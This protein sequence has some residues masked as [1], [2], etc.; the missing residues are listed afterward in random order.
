MKRTTW[1]VASAC[2][3]VTIIASAGIAPAFASD[4][5]PTENLIDYTVEDAAPTLVAGGLQFDGTT[6]GGQAVDAYRS[7]GV[8]LASVSGL[9]YTVATAPADGQADP[10]YALEVLTTGTGGYTTL[11]AEPYQN[12]LA[13]NA[14]GAFDVTDWKFWSSHLATDADGGQGQPEPLSWFEQQYP[15]AVVS[16]HGLHL[17]SA[18]AGSTSV[19]SA[20]SFDGIVT[21]FSHG[22]QATPIDVAAA[23]D[24]ATAVGDPTLTDV[25]PQTGLGTQVALYSLSSPFG[26]VY[27]D[28]QTAGVKA[29]Q[30]I[31]GLTAPTST[32]PTGAQVASGGTFVWQETAKGTITVPEVAGGTW[33][34]DGTAL[35][36]T[37]SF[38]DGTHTVTFT[39][40]SGFVVYPAD[41]PAAGTLAA[42]GSVSFTVTFVKGANGGGSAKVTDSKATTITGTAQ[43]G[44]ALTANTGTI[45]PST[46]KVAYQWLLNG[47]TLSGATGKTFTPASGG[48]VG[49]K[50]SVRVTITAAGYTSYTNTSAQTAAVKVGALTAPTPVITGAAKV[51][52]RLAIKLGTWTSGTTLH[53]QWYASGVAV[54]GQTYSS[55]TLGAAQ[56][57][58]V[59]AVKV[60]GSKSG[61]TTVVKTSAGTAKVAKGT[62]TGATPTVTVSSTVGGY[63]IVGATATAHS[64]AWTSGTAL[65]YQWYGNGIAIAG[66]TSS[67]YKIAASQLGHKLSVRVTGTK[68]GYNSLAKT[69]ASTAAAIQT[70]AYYA[71]HS[72]NKTT[73][74]VVFSGL[75]GSA[76]A[77]IYGDPG[78]AVVMYVAYP[79][80]VPLMDD[81]SGATGYY[82]TLTL[83]NAPS[84]KPVLDAIVDP[85]FDDYGNSANA[86]ISIYEKPAGAPD[87]YY[88]LHAK[89]SGTSVF[90]ILLYGGQ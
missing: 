8:P 21:D 9:G 53:Y 87:A 70:K 28:V 7:E 33:A 84:T 24:G 3:L 68:T 29:S 61:Y 52:T 6:A 46:A 85:G 71:A 23:P 49:K 30:A 90:D 58:K 22:Q 2:A 72:G 56:L 51:G 82:D 62:L 34:V 44:K 66:A 81:A 86:T 80:T 42:D 89:K 20:T 64:G 43:V 88:S 59:I 36:G 11:S 63:P 39:P 74:K 16:T 32:Q 83:P 78:E 4:A 65:H 73:Y 1:G 17:G 40:A 26:A 67:S 57:G 75:E 12:G 77:D 38:A 55:F 50:L 10:A 37:G 15:D 76:S 18:A 60:T 47:A 31:T 41:V 27:Y 25:D 19:V 13:L 45:A 48:Y 35:T 79:S 54:K 14:A 5:T 69:S